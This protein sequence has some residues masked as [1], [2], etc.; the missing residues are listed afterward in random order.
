MR[1]QPKVLKNDADAAAK[2]RQ[3]LAG[4]RHHILSEQPDDAAT[5]ALGE[6][7]E[8]QQR[9]LAR[10]RRAGQEIEAAAMQREADVGQRFAVQ[11]IAQA[12]IFELD[13]RRH[14]SMNAP[15]R[16]LLPLGYSHGTAGGQA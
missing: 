10:A 7:E 15:A 11:T 4:E 13:D 5:G 8:L 16:S 1:D 6:V 14:V 9:R 2:A 3:A 12:D